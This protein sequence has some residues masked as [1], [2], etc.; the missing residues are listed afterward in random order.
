ML[1]YNPT[2]L[3]LN[4]IKIV[5]NTKPKDFATALADLCICHLQFENTHVIDNDAQTLR[6]KT[7]QVGG[8]TYNV[9]SA[10]KPDHMLPLLQ[11]TEAALGVEMDHFDS[12]PMFL[13][14]GGQQKWEYFK[15]WEQCQRKVKMVIAHLGGMP[16][17][18]H[19]DNVRLASCNI[20]QLCLAYTM[21]LEDRRVSMS[22]WLEELTRKVHA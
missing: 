14:K 13:E 10:D 2:K 18:T 6:I 16:L 21:H 7:E 15:K 1:L 8:T 22:E 19:L 20:E 9:F 11:V 4:M 17:G 3:N 12:A 5:V